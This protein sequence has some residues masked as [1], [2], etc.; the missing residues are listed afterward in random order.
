MKVLSDVPY[1]VDEEVTI[2]AEDL[3]LSGSCNR[4]A[5]A[6]L[7]AQGL[8][9]ARFVRSGIKAGDFRFFDEHIRRAYEQALE[10]LGR[11]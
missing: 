9:W 1:E 8:D 7:R 5:R 3:R 4:G 10:R 6:Y 11:A 2:T